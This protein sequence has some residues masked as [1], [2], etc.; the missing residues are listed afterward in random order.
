VI[1]SSGT[2]SEHQLHQVFENAALVIFPSAYEG[3]GLPI[4]EALDFGVPV[5][6]FDTT[7]AREVVRKLR[8]GKGV[9]FFDKFSELPSI[10]TAALADPVLRE[11]ASSHRDSVRGLAPF[12]RK[13]WKMAI[14]QLDEPIDVVSLEKRFEELKKLERA[15]SVTSQADEHLQ[16]ELDAS[17]ALTSALV[18]SRTYR[19]GRGI[20][21]ITTPLRGIT[22]RRGR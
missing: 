22:R 15:W 21:W 8:L 18:A 11:A 16:Q 20:A 13:L 9:R 3:F 1:V 4:A 17:R 7:V 6:A 19:A 10:V 2:L 12:H 5:V 14:D